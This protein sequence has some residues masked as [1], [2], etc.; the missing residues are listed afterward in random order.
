MF[1][2]LP[3]FVAE[4]YYCQLTIF[5]TIICILPF[6]LDISERFQ[7]KLKHL[8]TFSVIIISVLIMLINLSNYNLCFFICLPFR[9]EK[10]DQF[11]APKHGYDNVGGDIDSP[12]SFDEIERPPLRH[13]DK[14]VRADFF[15]LSARYTVAFMAMMGFII[16]FGMKC[17]LGAAKAQRESDAANSVSIQIINPTQTKTKQIIL[18]NNKNI[19]IS[20]LHWKSLSIDFN[21]LMKLLIEFSLCSNNECRTSIKIVALLTTKNFFSNNI[22]YT[23]T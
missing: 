4:C 5:M 15:G 11:N 2:S 7:S 23:Y 12:T 18:N 22:H 8:D 13:I 19:R 21:W 20:Y 3:H 6:R 9:I 10:F 17:N 16:S 1:F 14:Y